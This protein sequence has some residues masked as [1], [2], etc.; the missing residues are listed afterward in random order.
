MFKKVLGA[1]ALASAMA[2]GA[3]AAVFTINAGES[4]VF[5]FSNPGPLGTG[6]V[7]LGT[8]NDQGETGSIAYYTGLNLTGT[9]VYTDLAPSTFSPGD[10]ITDSALVDGFSVLVTITT[11]SFSTQAE[12]AYYY[13]NDLISVVG[14]QS[15][16]VGNDSRPN[17]PPPNPTPNNVPEPG[18]FALVALAGLGLVAAQQ[19]R[20]RQG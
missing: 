13:A 3:Q 16:E 6:T 11:G 20:R 14:R 5:T 18:S 15:G 8:L 2:G 12:A 19:R 9:L 17:P 7:A 1:V 4:M 10:K